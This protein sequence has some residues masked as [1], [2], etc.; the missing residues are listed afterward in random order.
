[1][2]LLSPIKTEKAINKIE[3]ENTITFLV[4]T[5]ATKEAIGKECEKLFQV[6]VASVKTLITP[7][8]KKH[9]LIRLAKEFKA[10]DVAMKLK[11][12]A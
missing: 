11:M 6:K 8:G 2:I 9:A 4:S 1:M 7:N 5:E 3:F 12:I 10:D